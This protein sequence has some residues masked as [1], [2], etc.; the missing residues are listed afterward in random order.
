MRSDSLDKAD[1]WIFRH[2]HFLR[3]QSHLISEIKRS[4]HFCKFYL[5]PIASVHFMKNIFLIH[6]LFA[7][8][9]NSGNKEVSDLKHQVCTLTERLAALNDQV[10]KLTSV[11]SHMHVGDGPVLGTPGPASKKRKAISSAITLLPTVKSESTESTGLEA[12]EISRQVSFSHFD[13]DYFMAL[14]G[15]EVSDENSAMEEDNNDESMSTSFLTESE[16]VS[17]KKLLVPSL[18]KPAK[19]EPMTPGTSAV[20]A[21]RELTNIFGQLTPEL[22][23]RFIDK[24]AEVMGT[25]IAT[26]LTAAPAAPVAAVA[27][28][29]ESGE[30]IYRQNSLSSQGE[31]ILPSG[32]KAPEIALP[33]ASAAIGAYLTTLHNLSANLNAATTNAASEHRQFS[34]ETIS[35]TA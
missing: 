28:A 30:G 22:K 15:T 14:D 17:P 23:E 4:V 20:T 7:A 26:K 33:L 13:F 5:A 11:V 8:N 2:P 24:L 21:V 34:A 10:D 35:I 3:G 9:D 6:F 1:W 31:Y 12:P 27:A 32:S 19:D 25:Q 16:D 18:M 29:V